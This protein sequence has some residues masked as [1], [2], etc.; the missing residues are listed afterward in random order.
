MFLWNRALRKVRQLANAVSVL[1][2]MLVLT[3]IH[4][5]YNELNLLF[6]LVAH[7]MILHI[8]KYNSQGAHI[9]VFTN[10][11]TQSIIALLS[12]GMKNKGILKFNFF[13]KGLLA[14]L[15]K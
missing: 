14:F 4:T 7:I 15:I 1:I 8:G 5:N 13:L 2:T 12:C 6:P 11:H 3:L 10:I 9:H